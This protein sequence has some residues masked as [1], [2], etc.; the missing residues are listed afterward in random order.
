MNNDHDHPDP[1]QPIFNTNTVSQS[2]H[3]VD[4]LGNQNYQ[5]VIN[6]P[7]LN[8]GNFKRIESI[9]TSWNSGNSTGN[10]ADGFS[11][12]SSSQFTKSI[13]EIKKVIVEP[14]IEDPLR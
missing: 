9:K 2:D 3:P 14:L 12:G 11:A 5:S 4:S 7:G 6:N 13:G 10:Y 1:R 8:D